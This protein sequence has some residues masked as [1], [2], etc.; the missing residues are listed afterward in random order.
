MLEKARNMNDRYVE[1]V[2]LLMRSLPSIAEEKTFALKGGTAINLFYRNMPRLSVDIDL[3]Y[4][5]VEDRQTSLRN[6]DA[7][8]D[9]IS[10]RLAN[11]NQDMRLKRIAGG[12]NNETR[13]MI[14]RGR[15][16]VKVETSPVAR[17]TVLEP[18]LLTVSDTVQDDFGFA[19]MQ[20]VA[21]E[22]LY[23]ASCTPP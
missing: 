18:R 1:Q 20:V 15:A 6:I 3:V 8:P 12:G 2:R 22:D 17:G 16:Q 7:A 10:E 4:L 14:T 5:P 11:R 9:R 13:I 23:G 21:F 19:E